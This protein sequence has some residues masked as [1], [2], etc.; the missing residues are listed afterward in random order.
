MKGAFLHVYRNRSNIGDVVCCPKHY[1]PEFVDFP[2]YDI[3]DV[4]FV[5]EDCLIIGGGGLMHPGFRRYLEEALRA[6][7]AVLWGVGSNVHGETELQYPVPPHAFTLA[8]LRDWNSGFDYVP[9]PS[10]LDPVFD[11]V[12]EPKNEIVVY[13]H[14][15][16][17]LPLLTS[18]PRLDNSVCSL[19]EAA[20]F[21]ASGQIVLT[22]SFHGAYWAMLLNRRAI[23]YRPFSSRFFGFKHKLPVCSSDSSFFNAVKVAESY[24]DYLTECRMLNRLFKAQVVRLL[25]K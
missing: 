12:A 19:R 11:H 6:R 13:C 23:L 18:V 22:N 5:T 15:D 14:H 10:C 24:P 3:C 17:M 1:F 7:V 9:C 4:Q 2:V 16:V 20:Q 21:I 25:T 8:G